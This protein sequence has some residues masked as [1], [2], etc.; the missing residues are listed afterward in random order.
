MITRIGAVNYK[1][2]RNVS[3]VLDRFHVLTGPN[4]SGKSTFLEVPRLL[5][6]FAHDGLEHLWEAARANALEE[7]LFQGADL[8]FQLAVQAKPPDEILN[9]SG[10]SQGFLRYEIEVGWKRNVVKGQPPKILAESLWL[11]PTNSLRK[12]KSL[13]IKPNEFPSRS[14]PKRLIIRGGRSTMKP[15]TGWNGRNAM[16]TGPNLPRSPLCTSMACTLGWPSTG[17]AYAGMGPGRAT[18][19]HATFGLALSARS[20]WVVATWV[21]VS[22]GPKHAPSTRMRSP[23]TFTRAT[24]KAAANA[25]SPSAR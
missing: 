16:S 22:W 12:R 10:M 8:S 20:V 4:A 21:P 18:P 14:I 19:I 1:C 25:D 11:L 3:Q 5:G 2:L 17:R 23:N 24:S 13:V 7:L 6:A 9:G 15:G